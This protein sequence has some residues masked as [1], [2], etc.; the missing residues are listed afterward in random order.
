MD[1]IL[2][3]RNRFLDFEDTPE[4]EVIDSTDD[5]VETSPEDTLEDSK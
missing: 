1:Y 5:I 3:F 2:S 4:T